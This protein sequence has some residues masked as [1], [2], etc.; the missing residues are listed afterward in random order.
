MRSIADILDT[1]GSREQVARALS[2]SAAAVVNW[3]RRNSIPGRYWLA[4]VET[5]KSQGIK[6]VT[7]KELAKLHDYRPASS[8]TAPNGEAGAACDA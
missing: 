1:L 2:V 8:L 7:L 6:D 4:L 3:H 5:A